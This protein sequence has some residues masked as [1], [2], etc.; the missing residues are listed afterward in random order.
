VPFALTDEATRL[1]VVKLDAG[2]HGFA[3]GATLRIVEK[4]TGAVLDEWTSGGKGHEIVKLL[5]VD[6]VYVLREVAAPTG[7]A[8]SAP[9]EFRLNR[10]AGAGI[11]IVSGATTM[12]NGVKVK[13]AERFGDYGINLYNW[14]A[15]TVVHKTSGGAAA[16][17]TGDER[18]AFLALC[19]AFVAICVAGTAR[20]ARKRL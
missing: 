16:P 11:E 9:V 8:K 12:R 18:S 15:D 14:G 2:T 20:Y 17:R 5:D 10:N 1:E 4:S 3:K 6:T 19:L 13:N 7:Y